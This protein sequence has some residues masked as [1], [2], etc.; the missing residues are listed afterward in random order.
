LIKGD[1]KIGE[2]VELEKPAGFQ[3]KEVEENE[4][5]FASP[6]REKRGIPPTI[7]HVPK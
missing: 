6:F 3:G 4:R 5:D 1:V 7:L 2:F